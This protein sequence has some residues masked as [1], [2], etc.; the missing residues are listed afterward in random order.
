MSFYT[1]KLHLTGLW[2]CTY[3]KETLC[4]FPLS[5]IKASENSAFGIMRFSQSETTVLGWSAS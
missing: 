2:G 3:V 1:C 4:L 5:G